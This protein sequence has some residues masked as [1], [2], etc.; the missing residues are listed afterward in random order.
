MEAADADDDDVDA[1]DAADA[2][3]AAVAVPKID[4]RGETRGGV[5][6]GATA[7][8][9]DFAASAL[10]RDA[11]S[12]EDLLRREAASLELLL[13]LPLLLLPLPPFPPPPP[14]TTTMPTPTPLGSDRLPGGF[15]SDDFLLGAPGPR[16]SSGRGSEG[17]AGGAGVKLIRTLGRCV[18]GKE[19]EGKG[20]G[21]KK[22]SCK[23][24]KGTPLPFSFFSFLTLFCVPAGGE[25]TTEASGGRAGG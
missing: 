2:E 25:T 15:F 7:A 13:L 1:A 9:V 20:K 5:P 18:S 22:N 21:Q 23:R 11:L 24:Q 16:G 10:A 8:A 14:P 3:K 17:G 4:P 6:P 19:E 12:E